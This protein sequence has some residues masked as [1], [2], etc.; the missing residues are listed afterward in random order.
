M[1]DLLN[2]VN[3]RAPL[4]D[5]VAKLHRLADERRADNAPAAAA[6]TTPPPAAAGQDGQPRLRDLS[7]YGAA[8]DWGLRLAEDLHAYRQGEI[9]WADVDCGILLSGPPG[10]GKTFFARA[11][12]AECGAPLVVTTY[13]DWHASTI[14]DT[15]M[16]SLSA[17][18][19]AWRKQAEDGPIIVFVDEIDSIGARGGNGNGEAWHRTIINAWLAFLDGAEPR[20]GIVVIAA[21][22]SPNVSTRPYVVQDDWTGTLSCLSRQSTTWLA[23]LSSTWEARRPTTT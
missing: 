7:G 5:T 4:S 1:R 13:S 22:N 19:K 17:L 21:T 2:L 12:A 9:A 14:G 8:K 3:P 20:T 16:R 15:V 11:L 23:S 10:C 18:F 6:P